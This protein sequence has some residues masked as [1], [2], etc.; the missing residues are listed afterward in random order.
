MTSGTKLK[1]SRS[2]QSGKRKGGSR[3]KARRRRT[4]ALA[5]LKDDFSRYLRLA[6]EEEVVIT[7]HGRPAGVLVGFKDE[8]AW[9]DYQVENHPEFLKRVA[10]AREALRE[11][12]GTPLD[13]V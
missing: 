13:D 10:E 6:N 4:V 3:K 12:R 2:S 5:K 8:E 1:S 7:R 11:G 9:I